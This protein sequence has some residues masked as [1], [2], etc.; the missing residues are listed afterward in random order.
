MFEK[1]KNFLK[2]ITNFRGNFSTNQVTSGEIVF[3][4]HDKR[5]ML[6]IQLGKGNHDSLEPIS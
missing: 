4:L 3:P 1:E 2:T 6:L 5:G